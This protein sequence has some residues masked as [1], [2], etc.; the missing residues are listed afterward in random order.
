[1]EKPNGIVLSLIGVRWMILMV[2]VAYGKSSKWYS[3]RC[4]WC[5]KKF[6]RTE[7]RVNGTAIFTN[8]IKVNVLY[9]EGCAHEAQRQQA[10]EQIKRGEF[11]ES[12]QL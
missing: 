3:E 2:K 10:I 6:K 7:P 11:G 1:M 4:C 9:H 8:D 12:L 5:D